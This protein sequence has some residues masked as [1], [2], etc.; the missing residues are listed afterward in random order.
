[1]ATTATGVARPRG[2]GLLRELGELAETATFFICFLH[3]LYVFLSVFSELA[4][5]VSLVSLLLAGLG[6]LRERQ[7]EL[8]KVTILCLCDVSV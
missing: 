7:V 1:M 6:L 8:A 2:L 3:P 4:S 5:F